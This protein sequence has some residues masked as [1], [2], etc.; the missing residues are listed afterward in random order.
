MGTYTEDV[1]ANR[2]VQLREEHDLSQTDL[3]RLTGIS[4]STVS[5]LEYDKQK[6]SYKTLKELARI[7]QVPTDYLLGL[8]DN[9]E[10][11]DAPEDNGTAMVVAAPSNPNSG[12]DLQNVADEV[13]NL[14]VS[15]GETYGDSWKRR[16]GVGAAMMLLRKMDRFESIVEVSDWDVFK[17][18]RKGGHDFEDD[19]KDIVGYALLILAEHRSSS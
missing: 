1:F 6:P 14:L 3:S 16:G 5:Y 18:L 9:S 17:A 4:S 15:K 12:T 7:F 10:Y 8:S 11:L 2:L 13:V 19:L